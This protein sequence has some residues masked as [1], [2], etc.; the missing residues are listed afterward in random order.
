LTECAVQTYRGKKVVKLDLRK[1]TGTVEAR[2]VGMKRAWK[3]QS[4]E[5]VSFEMEGVTADM[6]HERGFNKSEV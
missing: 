3:K 6:Q 4:P 5:C 1:R 2:S